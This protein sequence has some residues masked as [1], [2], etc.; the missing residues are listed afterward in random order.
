MNTA[1]SAREAVVRTA[2]KNYGRFET[3]LERRARERAATTANRPD[4]HR[5]GVQFKR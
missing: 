5:A 1:T 2:F 3:K 4:S